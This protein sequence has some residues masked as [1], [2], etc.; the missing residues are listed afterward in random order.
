ML[1]SLPPDIHGEILLAAAGDE[2][3]IRSCA[4]V[5]RNWVELTRP[6]L[7]MELDLGKYEVMAAFS[8]IVV[9]PLMTLKHSITS[10]HLN[11]HL[12][13]SGHVFKHIIT[14]FK[15][16]GPITNLTTRGALNPYTM[17]AEGLASGFQHVTTLTIGDIHA[18]FPYV[19]VF[20]ALFPQLQALTLQQ[21][22]PLRH[23]YPGLMAEGADSEYPPMPVSFVELTIDH[24]ARCGWPSGAILA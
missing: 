14:H 16:L 21:F 18:S 11:V 8:S 7:K 4:L 3:F 19:P 2:A 22:H 23:H 10:V 5:C 17:R 6:L 9:S 24:R 20:L 13:N 12:V 1:P 15:R